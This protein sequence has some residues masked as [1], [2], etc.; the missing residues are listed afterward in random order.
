VYLVNIDF[1]SLFQSEAILLIL[2][3]ASIK[4]GMWDSIYDTF[5]VT[6]QPDS[7]NTLSGNCYEYGCIDAEPGEKQVPVA[8]ERLQQTRSE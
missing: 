3:V 4:C 5:Q 6:S 8:C 1:G 2:Q 7:A